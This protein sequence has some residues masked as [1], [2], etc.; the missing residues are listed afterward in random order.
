MTP[1]EREL[2][3][4]VTVLVRWLLEASGMTKRELAEKLGVSANNL[5][6]TMNPD[7]G[8]RRRKWTQGDVRGLAIVFEVSPWV[9]WGD[10]AETREELIEELKEELLDRVSGDVAFS[11]P[12]QRRGGSNRST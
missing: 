12:T 4:T 9:L 1:E 7:R 5:S 10:D 6:H 8:K 3:E 2:D 11:T